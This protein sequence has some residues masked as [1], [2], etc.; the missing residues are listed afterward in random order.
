LHLEITREAVAYGGNHASL[1]EALGADASKHS[2][3]WVKA[4]LANSLPGREG[5]TTLCSGGIS[6]E[7]FSPKALDTPWRE[8]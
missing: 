1:D 3:S 2:L 6:A 8:P 5:Q 7:E 4:A